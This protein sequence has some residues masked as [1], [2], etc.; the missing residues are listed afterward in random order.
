M[1]PLLSMPELGA[2]YCRHRHKPL[3]CHSQHPSQHIRLHVILWTRLDL[4]T[5]SFKN[6]WVHVV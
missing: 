3:L 5:L 4:Q 1:N 6:T 2:E